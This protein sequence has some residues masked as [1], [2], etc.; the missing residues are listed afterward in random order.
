MKSPSKPFCLLYKLH[1]SK[2]ITSWIFM[3]QYDNDFLIAINSQFHSLLIVIPSNILLK[4]QSGNNCLIKY[5][6]WSLTANQNTSLQ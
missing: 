1:V 4:Y 5:F 2:Q 6:I 3:A